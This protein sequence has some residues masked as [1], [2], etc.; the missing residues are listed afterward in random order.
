MLS[1][2]YPLFAILYR[3]HYNLYAVLL[4]VYFAFVFCYLLYFVFYIVLYPIFTFHVF[5]ILYLVISILYPVH[6]NLYE[7]R[8]GAISRSSVS[9]RPRCNDSPSVSASGQMV[10]SSCTYTSNRTPLDA[11]TKHAGGLRHRSALRIT[12]K[13]EIEEWDPLQ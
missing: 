9:S 11:T 5:T 8:C 12:K 1:S 3:V 13:T 10:G 6:F 4:I 7:V 2:L